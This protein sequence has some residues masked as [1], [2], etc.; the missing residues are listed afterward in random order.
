MKSKVVVW[1]NEVT[2]GDIVLVGGKGANLGDDLCQYPVFDCKLEDRLY[3][4]RQM[5]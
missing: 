4:A 1:F 2:K 5:V 3:E